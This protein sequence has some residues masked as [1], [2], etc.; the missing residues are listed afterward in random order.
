MKQ[1]GKRMQKRF[2]FH[3]DLIEGATDKYYCAFCD[4]FVEESHFYRDHEDKNDYERYT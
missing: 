4:L 2:Y 3:C 1:L